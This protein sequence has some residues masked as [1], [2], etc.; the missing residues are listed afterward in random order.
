[1]DYLSTAQLG[2]LL[3]IMRDTAVTSKKCKTLT[4]NLIE[5]NEDI[6]VAIRDEWKRRVDET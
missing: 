4:T 3:V 1:M 2:R 6:W 5:D